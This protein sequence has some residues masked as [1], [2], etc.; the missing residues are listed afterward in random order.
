[1]VVEVDCFYMFRAVHKR[2]DKG[3]KLGKLEN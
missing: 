2:R 3:L 1:M